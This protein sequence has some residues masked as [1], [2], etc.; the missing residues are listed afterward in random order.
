MPH[1]RD[2][3][4]STIKI[5]LIAVSAALALL[6]GYAIVVAATGSDPGPSATAGSP[7]ASGD[8]S[9]E[10][11][12]SPTS[13]DTLAWSELPAA[14]RPPAIANPR[15]GEPSAREWAPWVWDY[16]GSDWD[17][18]IWGE[19]NP[20]WNGD[21]P[22]TPPDRY[23]YQALYLVAPDGEHL[24]LYLLRTDVGLGIE[25]KALDERLVWITRYFYEASQTVEFDLVT[26]T[27]SETWADAGFANVSP[28]QN[29]NGWFVYHSAT[30]ADGRMMWEGGGYG[31]PLNGV[32]FRAPGG[33]I[34]PSAV[35]PNLG[36]G[37]DNAPFCLAVDTDANVAIYE[38]YAYA[39]GEPVAN[40]PARLVVHNL[41]ADT[42]TVQTRLG[43]YGTPCHDDFDV[44]ADY[45]VGLAN[46]ADQ[47]GLYR[48]YF[49][50][51]PDQAA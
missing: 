27:A 17:V 19:P 14:D 20:A 26:G 15:P 18:E 16:V 39:E 40:W 35:S 43:P 21:S 29:A 12:A 11:S 45:Y 25:A 42:W 6:V 34:T 49:D 3:G 5:A 50:G 24:R 44:T 32:F 7:S 4:A 8:P 47:S 46:R 22:D 41:V 10:P 31:E 38:G 1:R 36:G 33:A 37:L 13:S 2:T 28:T 9:L 23:L 30:L 48:Y 51:R